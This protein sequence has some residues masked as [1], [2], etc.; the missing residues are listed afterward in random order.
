M[1]HPSHLLEEPADQAYN[2]G[3]LS[4]V[5]SM[6]PA[7]YNERLRRRSAGS[8]AKTP[9]GQAHGHVTNGTWREFAIVQIL[10]VSHGW[11]LLIREVILCDA[12]C[13]L[14]H[15]DARRKVPRSPV[16]VSVALSTAICLF[17][18]WG[19]APSGNQETSGLV[20]QL[21]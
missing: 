10:R 17:G 12:L 8:K 1:C 20:Q 16:A 11:L 19:E 21:G 5:T 15:T 3:D 9:P 14:Y 2:T 7:L 13:I 4:P 6:S 18:Y